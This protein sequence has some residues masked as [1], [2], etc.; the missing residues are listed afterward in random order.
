ML[1][2]PLIPL[3]STQLREAFKDRPGQI[4]GTPPAVIERIREKGLYL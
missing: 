3:S 4:N 2:N 1:D